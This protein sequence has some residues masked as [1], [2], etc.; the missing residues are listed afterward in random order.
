MTDPT[1][2]LRRK[3]LAEINAEPGYCRISRLR[4]F[5]TPPQAVADSRSNSLLETG[6]SA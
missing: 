6:R 5:C 2:P 1:E 4:Y 3:R